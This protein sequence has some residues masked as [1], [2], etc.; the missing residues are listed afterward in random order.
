MKIKLEHGIPIP[1]SKHGHAGLSSLIR[2][3][4]VGDSFVWEGKSVSN[5]YVAAKIA[6]MRIAARTIGDHKFRV[7]RV[8]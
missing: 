7:W 6:D 3:M 8:K 4:K 2:S 5:V 1:N